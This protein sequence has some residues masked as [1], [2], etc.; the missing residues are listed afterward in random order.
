MPLLSLHV[1]APSAVTVFAR[2]PS[3]GERGSLSAAATLR[4]PPSASSPSENASK[5]DLFPVRPPIPPPGSLS[6]TTSPGAPPRGKA[7]GGGV[8]ADALRRRS[9]E[10]L[11]ASSA[12]V[13]PRRLPPRLIAPAASSA[14]SCESYASSGSSGAGP[15]ASFASSKSYR[16]SSSYR[17]PSSYRSRRAP[18]I[19]DDPGSHGFAT[20]SLP[21]KAP[22]PEPLEGAGSERERDDREPGPR[23]SS[24]LSAKLRRPRLAVG[25]PPGGEKEATA[26]PSPLRY[27][28]ASYD[29]ARRRERESGADEAPAFSFFSSR[30]RG[31]FVFA[32]ELRSSARSPSDASDSSK[33][34]GFEIGDPE[35]AAPNTLPGGPKPKPC[36]DDGPGAPPPPLPP[37]FRSSAAREKVGFG[38]R[39]DPA[40]DGAGDRDPNARCQSRSPPA[41]RRRRPSASFVVNG[42]EIIDRAP[43]AAAGPPPKPGDPAST[44]GSE[45]PTKLKSRA[46]PTDVAARRSG[47][48]SSHRPNCAAPEPNEP[49]NSPPADRVPSQCA[50]SVSASTSVV[51][52]STP[53]R[54]SHPRWMGSGGR[55]SSS[56]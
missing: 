20:S 28:S 43:R 38:F 26:P 48:A 34:G 23:L 41:A 29:P 16:S 22:D 27:R 54:K 36:G 42:R 24:S 1:C 21:R 45:A 49:P 40:L 10:A 18:V 3:Y 5:S 56:E 6:F 14:E 19:P 50:A 55:P 32:R 46:L 53:G 47:E 44:P 39:P 15:Y 7:E 4:I 35:T 13:P 8:G 31:V 12:S 11:D 17:S 2:P 37:R 51:A 30:P 9:S 52:R 33:S 25:L